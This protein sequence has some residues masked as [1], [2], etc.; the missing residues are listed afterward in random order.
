MKNVLRLPGVFVVM[1]IMISCSKKTTG[2]SSRSVYGSGN[3]T[4]S[5]AL[6]STTKPAPV[7]KIKTPTPKVIV[8]ND[9]IASKTFDG[10]LYYDLDGK[11]YWR[12]YKDGKYYLFNKSMATNPDFKKP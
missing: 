3:R 6:T 10:R 12:N 4:D 11:R 1:V 9:N 2:T 7:K 8:V 5:V